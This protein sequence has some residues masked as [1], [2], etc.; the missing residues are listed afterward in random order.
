MFSSKK[1]LI[2]SAAIVIALI[3][4]GYWYFGRSTSAVAPILSSS[5]AS[6]S[7]DLLSTLNELK[8]LSLN[9]AVFSLP[10][11]KALVS[12]TVTL[13]AVPAGKANPFAPLP[14][15]IQSPTIAP[16]ATH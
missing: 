7:D 15:L 14:G 2:L 11:F 10:S 5:T 16:S 9:A 4:F 1:N 3:V 12:D 6:S 8:S 13:S